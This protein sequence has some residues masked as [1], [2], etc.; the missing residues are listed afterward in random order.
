MIAALLI[1][2][3]DLIAFKEFDKIAM[4]AEIYNTNSMYKNQIQYLVSNEK[5]RNEFMEEM[6]K[7][8]HDF[9][10][11]LICIEEYAKNEEYELIID[12]IRQLEGKEYEAKPFKVYSGN[13]VIDYLLSE[14]QNWAQ[15]YQI[16]LKTD[17]SIPQNFQYSDFD[18]CVILANAIDNAIEATSRANIS[19]QK[20]IY[21]TMKY[22]KQS[23]YISVR[24]PYNSVI[25][26]MENDRL[27][28]TKKDRIRHGIGISSIKKAVEKYNGLV[29]ITTDEKIFNL[30][31]VL[32]R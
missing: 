15:D 25:T 13:R 10:N 20:T 2:I 16:C 7:N 12:Y 32:Y 23:L 19:N 18:I 27:I 11:H 28:S 26:K 30:E 29:S 9:K 21:L 4:D 6:Q 17:I 8:I 5:N 22:I 14:K 1:L 24:N 3:I 31:V